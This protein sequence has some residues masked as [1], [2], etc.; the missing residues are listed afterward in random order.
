MSTDSDHHPAGDPKG[1]D[2]RQKPGRRWWTL[3]VLAVAAGTGVG[4]GASSLAQNATTI[5]ATSNR[6]ITSTGGEFHRASGAAPTWTL[7]SLRH[8]GKN[9]SLAQFRGHPVVVNFW[10]S[11]CPPCRKEMP[12]LATT[13]RKLGGNVAVVGIDTND[14]RGDAL[15]FAAQTG[16]RYPLAYDA[17]AS[18]GGNYA[19]RGLPTTFF[20]SATG[21]VVGEQVGGMTAHRFAQLLHTAFGYTQPGTAGS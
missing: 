8:P 19:V 21:Q 5:H 18:V 6:I 9:V 1:T 16:V 2:A 4:E 11:W 7:P 12:A 15:A 3:A 17:N 10:A 20:I 13:A 14:A